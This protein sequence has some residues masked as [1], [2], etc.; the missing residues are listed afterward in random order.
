[1]VIYLFHNRKIVESFGTNLLQDNIYLN[2]DGLIPRTNDI[3][4]QLMDYHNQYNDIHSWLWTELVP[5]NQSVNNVTGY[6]TENTYDSLSYPS[7]LLKLNIR[8]IDQTM[9]K[10]L[11]LLRDIFRPQSQ[12]NSKFGQTGGSPYN[13]MLMFDPAPAWHQ[14]EPIPQNLSKLT[15]QK[16]KTVQPY[17]LDQVST[18]SIGQ[19]TLYYD[20]RYPENMVSVKFIQNPQKYCRQHYNQYPCY[21]YW[22]KIKATDV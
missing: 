8:P 17:L 14:T 7:M 13:S 4:S 21:R 1:M 12:L 15:V 6:A 20:A 2:N 22:S 10:N 9:T 19:D 5:G 16:I 11:P 3:R 18:K